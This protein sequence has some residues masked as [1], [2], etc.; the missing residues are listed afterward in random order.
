MSINIQ[1][2]MDIRVDVYVTY[3]TDIQTFACKFNVFK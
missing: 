2:D 1:R 3:H